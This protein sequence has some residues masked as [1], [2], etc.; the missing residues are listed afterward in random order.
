MPGFPVLHHLLEL[1]QIMSIQLV[2]DI[3]TSNLG[4]KTILTRS[5]TEMRMRWL[6]SII[7]VADLFKIV[8]VPKLLV[9]MYAYLTELI[10]STRYILIVLSLYFLH[11]LA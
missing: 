1:A 4:T 7:Y 10:C 8:L 3:N 9:Y 2:M 11:F 6:N 5:T